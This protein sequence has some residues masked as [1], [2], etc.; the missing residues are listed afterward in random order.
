MIH[1]HSAD[2]WLSGGSRRHEVIGPRQLSQST[3]ASGEHVDH[4]KIFASC[5]KVRQPHFVT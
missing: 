1:P 4:Y 3:Q 2:T 5:S